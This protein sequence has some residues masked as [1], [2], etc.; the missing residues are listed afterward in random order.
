ME[1]IIEP[2]L[3]RWFTAPYRETHPQI[4]DRIAG[5]LR[6]T[7]RVG[8]VGCCHAVSRINLTERLKAIKCPTSVMVGAHD[9]GTP[10]AMARVIYH[11][12]PATEL[13]IVPSAAHLLNIEQAQ[14]FNGALLSFLARAAP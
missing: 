14:A 4:M 8:Y 10:V 5:Y 12:L 13:V 3:A 9:T 1:I 11:A 6:A 7:P 2:T